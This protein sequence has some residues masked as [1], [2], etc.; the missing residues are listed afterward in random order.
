MR[1]SLLELVSKVSPL[2]GVGSRVGIRYFATRTSARP[3]PF[4]LWSEVPKPALPDVQGP[5]SDYTSWPVL[6]DRSFSGRH[7]APADPAYTQ[8]LP[9]DA[10]YDPTRQKS[11]QVTALFERQGAMT[12]DRSSVLFAFFAQWFTDSVL[13]VHPVDRRMNTSNHDIDLCQIYGLDE[14]TARI[15]RS[16][17]DGTLTS[18]LIQ[19][20][21]YPDYL[22][23]EDGAGGWTPRKKYEGLPYV[24]R[25]GQIFGEV[26]KTRWGKMYATGL[27]RGNS[28]IGY[29]AVSTI[30]LREH[31]RLCRELAQRNPGWSDER[32]F[33]T[34]R[35]INIVL[36]LKLVVE[37]YINHIVGHG[38]FR[39]DTSF[40]E[41]ERWYRPNWIALEFDLLYR[42]HGLVPDAIEI[43]GES[44]GAEGFRN[45]NALLEQAGV[46]AVIDAASR[47][48][49]GRIGLANT[50]TFL[51]GAEYQALKMGRDF[52]LRSYN[53]YRERFQLKRLRSFSEL[54]SD[55]ALRTKLE[56]LYGHIDKLEYLVGVFAEDRKPPSLFGDLLTH[57]VAYDAFK[58]IF[59]NPLLA[60]EIHNERTFTP[61]GM[62]QIEETRSIEDLVRRNVPA[63]TKVRASLGVR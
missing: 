23:E 44:H 22:F 24:E 30:F 50:P 28:S 1:S 3:R 60:R 42:W 15:L 21:E 12:P 18:Q 33:Q 29:V 55:A 17:R 16:G 35:M 39:L 56:S 63:G 10:P 47:Q 20:Q 31:N 2:R 51:W 62:K 7:L 34:A 54:T 52:R 61:Y 25:V 32:I 57:M 49:A 46:A 53:D 38:L 19:G 37:D 4:S 58:Q 27:E 45:N 8:S 40:A 36:L 14:A 26:R 9:P 59:S 41:G 43:G 5:V 13:R 11:G 6:T 48:H